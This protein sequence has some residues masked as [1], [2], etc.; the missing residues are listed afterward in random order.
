M[1]TKQKALRRSLWA[2]ALAI[3]LC[4][5]MLL[6]TTFAWFT[7]TVSSANN[8]IKSGT[9][10]IQ[11]N[12]KDDAETLFTSDDVLWEPGYSQKAEFTVQN[13]GSLWL[14]YSLQVAI[15]EDTAGLANVLDVYLLNDKTATNLD[16]A[17]FLGTV[18]DLA[19]GL[20]TAST[21]DQPLAPGASAGEKVLVIK[22]KESAGNEYQNKEI[23]FDINILATQYTEETD[24][25]G[26]NQYDKDAQY[27]TVIV[28]DTQELVDALANAEDGDIIMLADNANNISI[29]DTLTVTAKDLVLDGNGKTITGSVAENKSFLTV[30]TD[31]D[32]TMTD[33]TIVPGSTVTPNAS[34]YLSVEGKVTITDCVFGAPDGTAQVMY[35]GLEFDSKHPLADG[36]VISGNTFYGNSFRHNCISF[37]NVEEGA[38]VEISNN[39]FID[40][41]SNTTNAIRISNWNDTT[42]TININSNVYSILQENADTQ[43]AGLVLF[44]RDSKGG[45]SKTTININDLTVNGKVPTDNGTGT[46]DQIAVYY[47]VDTSNMP[48]INLNGKPLTPYIYS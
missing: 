24:G 11:L 8:T 1:Q 29:T 12:G 36:S 38:T 34:M 42:A 41:N 3:L 23:K 26:S 22:M 35:N 14:K 15:K 6:G 9:L 46:V 10:L 28:S 30:T 39:K 32:F 25:F 47:Q 21:K 4:I 44:Q 37:Y 2:S 5:A 45:S 20:G 48:A 19:A 18:A 40:L 17:A 16:D 7:D 43:W 33:V 27:P 31:G 13:V